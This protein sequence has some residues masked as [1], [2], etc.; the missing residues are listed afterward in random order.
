VAVRGLR[1]C[2]GGQGGDVAQQ[3]GPDLRRGWAGGGSVGVAEEVA[4]RQVA[5]TA[6]LVEDPG[7]V[8]DGL[9]GPSEGG[10]EGAGGVG[11]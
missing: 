3:D 7:G 8:G 6:V 5:V 1:G 9:T 2:F 11:V 10:G 4:E